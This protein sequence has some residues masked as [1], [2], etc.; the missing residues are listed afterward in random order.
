M[1][2]EFVKICKMTQ[3][4]LKH[5]TALELNAMCRKVTVGNGFVFAKG[6]FPV[7]LVAHLDTVHKELPSKFLY[8]P[9]TTTISAPEGIGGDDRC[10][11]YMALKV[12]KMYDCSVL[13]CEDEEIG[14]VG[15][16]KFTESEVLLQNS[17]HSVSYALVKPNAF[18]APLSKLKLA[19]DAKIGSELS[20]SFSKITHGK[21]LTA[22]R[23]S[24]LP[25]TV[26]PSA[27]KVSR[28][29]GSG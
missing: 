19:L 2:R 16:E 12:A 24:E 22:E 25:A 4:E 18:S 8:D 20:V 5:H 17:Q 10:G 11:V 15:A 23:I 27:S 26:R 28:C 6:S 7:C 1:D 29:G 3:K 13:F 14:M 21:P 9:A